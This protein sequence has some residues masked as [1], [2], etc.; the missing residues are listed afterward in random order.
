MSSAWRDPS[1]RACSRV[2]RV[3]CRSRDRSGTPEAAG[4]KGH[5]KEATDD[6][7]D[8]GARGL[9]ELLLSS[10]IVGSDPNGGSIRGRVIRKKGGVP[11]AR[12]RVT[13]GRPDSL[14][15]YLRAKANGRFDELEVMTDENGRFAFTELRRRSVRERGKED[16]EAIQQLSREG[17]MEHEEAADESV[18]RRDLFAALDAA[19]HTRLSERQRTAVLAELRGLPTVEIAARLETNQ[20]AL[21]KLVHDARKKLK[22]ALEAAGFSADFIHSQTAGGAA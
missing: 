22:V 1:D 2:A 15:T 20:N 10:E 4:L 19:I 17:E 14:I 7:P 12:V 8:F 9:D 21:Y 3:V 16:F 6:L 11:M 18:A 13:L 5:G